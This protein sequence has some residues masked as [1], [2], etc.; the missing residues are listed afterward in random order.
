M[1]KLSMKVWQLGLIVKARLFPAKPG[2]QTTRSFPVFGHQH[3]IIVPIHQPVFLPKK[4]HRNANYYKNGVGSADYNYVIG[5]FFSF[6]LMVLI[7]NAKRMSWLSYH[8]YLKNS[9]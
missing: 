6:L 4:I 8:G 7:F 5:G 1:A 2:V 3:N 9:F